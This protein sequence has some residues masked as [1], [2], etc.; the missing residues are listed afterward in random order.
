MFVTVTGS[1][2][3]VLMGT[4]GSKLAIGRDT[5]SAVGVGV[6][7]A[8]GLGVGVAVGVGL[9]VGVPGVGVG[10]GVPG[11]GVGL[12][13]PGVGVG[14]PAVGV[15]VS[16]GVGVGVG[17][18]PVMVMRPLV[19]EGENESK[20]VSMKIKSSGEGCQV[21]EVVAPGVVLTL[22][23]LKLYNTPAPDS[24]VTPSF[25]KAD[26]RRVLTPVGGFGRMFPATVQPLPVRPAA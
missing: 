24:G 19:W 6:G 12:G 18:A 10:L 20:L 26:T 23:I 1:M 16:V 14:V 4:E 17:V 8:V 5:V 9:G 22:T 25:T 13:V 2:I 11:V 3:T 7:G 21:S 15:G